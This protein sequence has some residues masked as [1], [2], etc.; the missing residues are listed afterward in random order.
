MNTIHLFRVMG[1]SLLAA[2]WLLPAA[3]CNQ[4]NTMQTDQ[5]AADDDPQWQRGGGG[6]S[7]RTLFGMG[8]ILAAQGKTNEAKFILGKAITQDRKF[9]PAYVELAQIQLR[10][11]QADQAIK[12]LQEGLRYLPNDSVMTN[13]VGMCYFLQGQYARAFD[14]FQRAAVAL[15]QN[16]RY[17]ANMAMALGM[18]GRYEEATALYEQ[19]VPSHEAHYNVAVL[20]DARH[21]KDRANRE[22]ATAWALRNPTPVDGATTQPVQEP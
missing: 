2:L 18:Q 11:R 10:E 16:A 21:D 3:G 4:N 22:Y 15:P 6:P 1:L 13:D 5:Y 20:A 19:V 9:A 12:V 17:R 8:K 14:W 7:A